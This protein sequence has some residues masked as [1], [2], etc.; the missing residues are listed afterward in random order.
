VS[1]PDSVGNII[2]PALGRYPQITQSLA[3]AGFSGPG[4]TAAVTQALRTGSGPP[5]IQN[6]I[7]VM[8]G[9]EPGRRP[10]A[11]ATSPLALMAMQTTPTARLFGDPAGGRVRGDMFGPD[12]LD[13]QRRTRRG[14]QSPGGGIYPASAMGAAP[15]GRRTDARII[16]GRSFR[17]GTAIANRSRAD[18]LR[19]VELVYQAVR[20]M[21]FSDT[22][23]L[24][25][26]I[27]QLFDRFD[28]AAGV[29]P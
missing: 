4:V 18:L 21:D 16:D 5:V 14:L 19:T 6:L 9:A 11:A 23:G 12:M 7:G 1:S 10:I 24:R 27:L 17:E 3:Q 20:M 29:N 25:R 15:A 26:E 28:R 8:F 13:P 22:A 2:V